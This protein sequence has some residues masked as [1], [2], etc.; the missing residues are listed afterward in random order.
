M[1]AGAC[2]VM[3]PSEYAVLYID[4]ESVG[5]DAPNQE[6]QDDVHR[7]RYAWVQL[8]VRHVLRW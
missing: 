4:C 6:L 3:S 5:S 2:A 1:F 7:L 8:Q